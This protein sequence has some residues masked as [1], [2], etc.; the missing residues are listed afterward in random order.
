MASKKLSIIDQRK[1]EEA[2]AA[3]L[4]AEEFEHPRWGV[5][6]QCEFPPRFDKASVC[7]AL[8]Q[9]IEAGNEIPNG[10]ALVPGCGRGYDVTALA[11]E[12]RYCLGVDIVPA[13]IFAAEQ[14][15][16]Q[17]HTLNTTLEVP[18]SPP[19]GQAEFRC[20]SFFD[21]DTTKPESLFD[22]VYDYTF[23][24]AL[25]PRI[26]KDWAVKMSELVKMGGELLT[27]VFPIMDKQDGP[28]YQLK[29]EEVRDLLAPVG[30]KA[31]RSELLPPELCHD[32]RAGEG[33]GNAP[34]S[35]IMRWRRVQLEEDF[36][37][38]F[39]D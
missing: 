30:F 7:P 16:E 19:I 31:F 20:C 1:V 3:A 18:L 15:L 36:D 38:E 22:F 23:L 9:L 27:L 4:L 39:D 12:S 2:A 10:R 29:M 33:G 21:L 8:A 26:R 32:G 25:D 35:G 34:R 37:A 17:I 11:S 13:A 24:C 5:M 28:P 6:W 14:R